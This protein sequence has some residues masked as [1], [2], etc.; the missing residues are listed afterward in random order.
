[1]RDCSLVWVWLFGLSLCERF[2]F[3]CFDWCCMFVVLAF[4]CY[5]FVFF[6]SLVFGLIAVCLCSLLSVFCVCVLSLLLVG[7]VW[8]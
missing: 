6:I 4:G 3:G 8:V 5:W 7:W 1:M 2:G